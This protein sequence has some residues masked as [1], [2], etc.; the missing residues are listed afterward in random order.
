MMKKNKNIVI[1]A[2]FI[3]SALV[4]RP[5]ILHAAEVKLINSAGCKTEYHLMKDLCLAYEEKT[6]IEIRTGKTGNKKAI[7]LM[8]DGKVDFAFTCKPIEKLSQNLKLDKQKTK[9][10][11]SIAIA[12]DPLVIVSNM[13]N[14]IT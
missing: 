13:K 3:I 10:W 2:V 14:G 11:K 9:T 1:G 8:L 6:G 4:I 12:K 5:A 7:E